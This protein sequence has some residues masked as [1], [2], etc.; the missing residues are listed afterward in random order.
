MNFL[1]TEE[2]LPAWAKAYGDEVPK[3]QTWNTAAVQ[4]KAASF[5]PR[6]LIHGQANARGRKGSL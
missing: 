4:E 6:G 1:K 3:M 5:A 2:F